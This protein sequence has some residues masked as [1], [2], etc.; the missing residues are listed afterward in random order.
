VW[1]EGCVEYADGADAVR[2]EY[3]RGKVT[4]VF[5]KKAEGELRKKY[6]YN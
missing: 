5:P 6:S 4:G 3:A 1:G 2:I